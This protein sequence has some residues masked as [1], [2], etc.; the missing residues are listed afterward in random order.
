MFLR[1]IRMML[2]LREIRTMLRHREIR[3]TPLQAIPTMPRLRAIRT[4]PRLRA[5]RTTL[6]PATRTTPRC[7]PDRKHRSNKKGVASDSSTK[8]KETK[9]NYQDWELQVL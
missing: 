3:M 7:H 1:V 6:P 5:I 2:H 9:W 8:D 4:T